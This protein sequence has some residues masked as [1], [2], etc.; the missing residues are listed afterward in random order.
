MLKWGTGTQDV[1]L[2]GGAVK[3]AV[4]FILVPMFLVFSSMAQPQRSD[5]LLVNRAALEQART[6]I[7]SDR[8]SS[9]SGKE[10]YGG[11]GASTES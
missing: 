5:V 1:A 2:G 11:C 8:S 7:R 6:V 10:T 3:A 9:S 4:M